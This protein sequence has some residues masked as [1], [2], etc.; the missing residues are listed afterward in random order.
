[1]ICRIAKPSDSITLIHVPVINPPFGGKIYLGGGGV[2][3]NTERN[4]Y[5][6]LEEY[7]HQYDRCQRRIEHLVSVYKGVGYNLYVDQIPSFQE[8]LHRQLVYMQRKNY[9]HAQLVQRQR[10]KRKHYE[11]TS[12]LPTHSKKV[13]GR[14]TNNRGSFAPM[15]S[16]RQAAATAAASE[17]A[18]TNIAVRLFVQNQHTYHL[19][20]RILSIARKL[21]ASFF[22]MGVES[23]DIVK[24]LAPP[25]IAV[26][27]N[28]PMGSK[29]MNFP[30]DEVVPDNC[31]PH[32]ALDSLMSARKVNKH[33]QAPPDAAKWL[34]EFLKYADQKID[35]A[36]MLLHQYGSQRSAPAH[37]HGHHHHHGHGHE[38]ELHR[39]SFLLSN[40]ES[41]K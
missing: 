5:F 22:V 35:L 19:S 9:F 7:Q 1:M 37:G 41:L 23:E 30:F 3:K 34:E 16:S 12:K 27:N 14:S 15:E 32:D 21:E 18:E 31:R 25:T 33:G 2:S 4:A 39:F 24:A 29:N 38:H 17:G 36:E 10:E 40:C 11:F 28:V 26:I 13:S 8:E 20:T 6:T